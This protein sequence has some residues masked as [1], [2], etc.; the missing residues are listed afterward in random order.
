MGRRPMK[1]AYPL[2]LREGERF[3]VTVTPQ[4]RPFSSSVLDHFTGYFTLA[5]A[6]FSRSD[7]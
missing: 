6:K 5:G 1:Y 4:T 2:V 3:E 7:E